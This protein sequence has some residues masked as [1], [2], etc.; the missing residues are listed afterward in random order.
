MGLA[1]QAQALH[2]KVTGEYKA[3]TIIAYQE[4]GGQATVKDKL[5]LEFDKDI[6][7]GKVRPVT[8]VN[9]PST[10]TDVSQCREIV[11]CTHSQG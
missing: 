2:F 8:F 1:A 6:K 10:S 11:P 3:R 9:F 4:E 5:M 7:T